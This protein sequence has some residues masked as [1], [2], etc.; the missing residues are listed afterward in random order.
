MALE[1]DIK[2]RE[3]ERKIQVQEFENITS[4]AGLKLEELRR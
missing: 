4:R 2:K 1:L 3:R